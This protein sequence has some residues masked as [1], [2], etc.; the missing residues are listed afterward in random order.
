MSTIHVE[1][2]DGLIG[3]LGKESEKLGVWD[4]CAKSLICSSIV[5]GSM[6]GLKV[7]IRMLLIQNDLILW[8]ASLSAYFI[9]RAARKFFFNDNSPLDIKQ[10]SKIR[11][12][13]EVQF[14]STQAKHLILFI[15]K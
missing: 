15:G 13:A 14:L 1:G 7:I 5:G 6:L 8:G 4:S 9:E 12:L 10:V 2:L 3:K 11:M